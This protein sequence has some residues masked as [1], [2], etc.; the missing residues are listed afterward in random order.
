MGQPD[1]QRAT[2][3][4]LGLSFFEDE[5]FAPFHPRIYEDTE[6]AVFINERADFALISPRPKFD[7]ERYTPR[8]EKLGLKDAKVDRRYL[9]A[10]L[11]RLREFLQGTGV[12]E[13]ESLLEIGANDGA[14]LAH[15]RDA[16]PRTACTGV[17]PSAPHRGVAQER[18]L[19]MFASLEEVAP[20][21]FPLVCMFHVFEHF[22]NPVA[23]VAKM[24]AALAPGGIF[25]IEIP[26]LTDPLVSLYDIAAFKDFYFQAQHPFV[27][28]LPSV[29]RLLE[30]SGQRILGTSC[31]QRYGL[32]NH[33][34]WLKHHRPGRDEALERVAAAVEPAYTRHLE[35]EGRTDTVFVCFGPAK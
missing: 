26:S 15:L 10:R 6:H 27:Y 34:Q 24:Q 29:R 32:G 31:L 7:Y 1:D 8:T 33:L 17:E 14:F 21:K 22:E 30:A 11:V 5:R 9:D 19:A 18:G 25:V 13:P 28:S 3:R 16:F 20:R 35:A 2:G 4:S 23:E 12:G